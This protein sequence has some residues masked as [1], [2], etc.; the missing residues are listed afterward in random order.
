MSR[1][2]RTIVIDAQVIVIFIVAGF[3]QQS[4]DF[5]CVISFLQQDSPML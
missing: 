1:L 4:L 2:Y 3:W 5:C